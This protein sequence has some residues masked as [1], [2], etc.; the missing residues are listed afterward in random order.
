MLR[1]YTGKV[2]RYDEESELIT[3]DM[4]FGM[5]KF[6]HVIICLTFWA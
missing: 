3:E 2:S 1:E 4:E 5:N 6:K